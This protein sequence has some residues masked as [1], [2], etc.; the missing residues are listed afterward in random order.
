[1]RERFPKALSE[2]G[3]V[4][5]VPNG[6]RRSEAPPRETLLRAGAVTEVMG[7]LG[8]GGSDGGSFT[9][10]PAS[11]DHTS[12]GGAFGGGRDPGGPRQIPTVSGSN[13]LSNIPFIPLL[14]V[15]SGLGAAGAGLV[16]LSKNKKT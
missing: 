8:S 12:S 7:T 2:L 15:L 6:T 10:A 5:P 3:A 14:A 13:T 1:M 9:D 4:A 16:G 11:N